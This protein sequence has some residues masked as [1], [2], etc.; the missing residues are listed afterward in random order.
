MFGQTRRSVMRESD[1]VATLTRLSFSQGRRIQLDQRDEDDTSGDEVLLDQ[2]EGRQLQPAGRTEID[3][4][5]HGEFGD[6]VVLNG[7]PARQADLDVRF[8]C[9][10]REMHQVLMDVVVV[11]VV[12]IMTD[13]RTIGFG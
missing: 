5:S 2:M 7:L 1:D 6:S 12:L 11:P 9:A 4:I 3:S 8:V 10:G 13:G